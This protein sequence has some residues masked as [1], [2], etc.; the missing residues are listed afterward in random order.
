MCSRARQHSTLM[1]GLLAYDQRAWHG[2]LDPVVGAAV[3]AFGVIYV[4][5]FE[6]GNGRIH[7]W[8]LHHVLATG[9]CAP[10]IVVFP[11]RAAICNV[12][13]DDGFSYGDY[14]EQLTY[15]LFLEMARERTQAPWSQSSIIPRGSIGPPTPRAIVMRSGTSPATVRPATTAPSPSPTCSPTAG[16]CRSARWVPGRQR[17]SIRSL[18]AVPRWVRLG[19]PLRTGSRPAP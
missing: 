7:R 8:L 6:D 13:R 4:H 16:S 17:R 2:A 9:G 15:L 18:Q 12:P 11:V 10:P 3:E 1:R 14:V 5:P 19:A